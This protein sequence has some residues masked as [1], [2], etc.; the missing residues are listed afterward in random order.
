MQMPTGAREARA[1]RLIPSSSSVVGGAVGRAAESDKDG[2]RPL[3]GPG[4]KAGI[5]ACDGT[6]AR[7]WDGTSEEERRRLLAHGSA[8]QQP[9][10]TRLKAGARSGLSVAS[11]RPS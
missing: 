5:R 3:P 10:P 11:G 7:V 2:L 1:F 4:G 9:A 6:G 8:T